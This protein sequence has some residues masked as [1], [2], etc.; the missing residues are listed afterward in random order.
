[1]KN[2]SDHFLITEETAAFYASQASSDADVFSKDLFQFWPH[3]KV[4]LI[5][6]TVEKETCQNRADYG[7]VWSSMCRTTLETP[8]LIEQ[9]R[10]EKFDI[11]I[12]ENIDMCGMGMVPFPFSLSNK[13]PIQ[14]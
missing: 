12:T 7:Y 4:S 1:M 10:A 5:M 14:A 2:E 8:G 9:L 6:K 13:N 11:M 3:W